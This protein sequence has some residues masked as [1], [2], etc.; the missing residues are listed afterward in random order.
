MVEVHGW[1]EGDER[2]VCVSHLNKEND[3]EREKGE[4]F[5]CMKEEG[6]GKREALGGYS[7]G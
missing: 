3:E 7:K 2:L 6:K 5:N 4:G 1:L